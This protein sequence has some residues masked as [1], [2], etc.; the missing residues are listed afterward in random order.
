MAKATVTILRQMQLDKPVATA[1]GGSVITEATVSIAATNRTIHARDLKLKRLKR[2]FLFPNLGAGTSLKMN[3]ASGSI[4]STKVDNN[5]AS[6]VI[7][8]IGTLATGG[9][10]AKKAAGADHVYYGLFIGDA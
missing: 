8:H 7:W 6:M 3:I 9:G 2:M 1:L 4:Q 10:S 5:F